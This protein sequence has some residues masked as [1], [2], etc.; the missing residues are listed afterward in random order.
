MQVKARGLN[1]ATLVLGRSEGDL[2]LTCCRF[3]RPLFVP[4]R[5][6]LNLHVPST[7]ED[8][9]DETFVHIPIWLHIFLRIGQQQQKQ[10][11]RVVGK[12]QECTNRVEKCRNSAPLQG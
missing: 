12:R 7:K 11:Q 1:A 10:Q 9:D 8:D 5:G 3:V 2:L 4:T 6:T